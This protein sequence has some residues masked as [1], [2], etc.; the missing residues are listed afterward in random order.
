M[1]EALINIINEHDKL[2]EKYIKMDSNPFALHL[3]EKLHREG[4]FIFLDNKGVHD[5]KQILTNM[6]RCG[7]D[8]VY[9]FDAW[10]LQNGKVI[11]P[12]GKELL[13]IL[14][15]LH[16]DNASKMLV[17]IRRN[18]FNVRVH[19]NI[20]GIFHRTDEQ[21]KNDCQTLGILWENPNTFT[22]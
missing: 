18:L 22:S 3:L 8:Y 2:D 19:F 16:D 21:V 1:Q 6:L 12:N 5:T 15:L 4:D 11:V 20:I 14:E 7:S 13:P 10:R 17:Y 9:T